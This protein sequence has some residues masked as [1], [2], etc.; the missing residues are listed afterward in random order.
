MVGQYTAACA[1]I[2]VLAVVAAPVGTAHAQD[3]DE[4]IPAWIR[5]IFVYYADEQISDAELIAALTY[6]I[7]NGIIETGAAAST[8]ATPPT[9]VAPTLASGALTVDDAYEAATAATMAATA[10]GTTA[11][12]AVDNA[13]TIDIIAIDA[14]ANAVRS[15]GGPTASRAVTH[16]DVSSRAAAMT[17]I[18]DV[19]QAADSGS[20]DYITGEIDAAGADVIRL[21]NAAVVASQIADT[22]AYGD[23]SGAK[24]WAEAAGAWA[25][26]SSAQAALAADRVAVLRTADVAD[27][28]S[29]ASESYAAVG[30]SSVARAFDEAAEAWSE[31]AEAWAEAAEAAERAVDSWTAAAEAWDDAADAAA[32]FS[33]VRTEPGGTGTAE[34]PSRSPDTAR[35][36]NDG[37]TSK[38]PLTS[39]ERAIERSRIAGLQDISGPRECYTLLRSMERNLMEQ[40]GAESQIKYMRDYLAFAPDP[41]DPALQ[42]S[43]ALLDSST[44]S[45][46]VLQADYQ[47]MKST[48]ESY[49]QCR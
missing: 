20:E 41:N 43:R 44:E 26:V 17:A 35:P 48:Y 3:E 16:A 40:D 29:G 49:S 37:T 5:Q 14:T 10:D 38:A 47:T 9:P 2:A 21:T 42:Q 31:S 7:D 13:L 46:R 12:R 25:E 28:V 11:I 18:D 32:V 1:A 19:K 27:V 33:K 34:T 15:A 36:T 24:A 39:A 8:P 4:L 22:Y 45:L 6:L 30:A 23:A